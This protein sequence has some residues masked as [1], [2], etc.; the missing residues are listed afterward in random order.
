MDSTL[1]STIIARM[2]RWQE[3]LPTEEQYLVYDLDEALRTQI[4][5]YNFPWTLKKSTLKVFSEILE[6]PVA[7]D[8]NALA[9]IDGKEET[10]GEKPRPYYTSIIEFYQDPNN[11][12]SI[13]EIWDTGTRYL[14]VRNKELSGQNTTIDSAT[15]VTGY[16]VSGDATAVALDPVVTDGKSYSVAVS[17]TYSSNSFLVQRTFDAIQDTNYQKKYYFR[18][19]YIP[20]TATSVTLRYGTDSSNYLY[21]TVTTQFSGQPIKVGDFNWFAFDLNEGSVQGSGITNSTFAYEAVSITGI[22]SGT[23]YLSE[24]SV[25]QWS[26]MDYWYYSSYLIKTE[27]SSVPDREFFLDTSLVYS[28]DSSLIGDKEF[29]DVVMYEALMLAVA[30]KENNK[31]FGLFEKRS[32]DAWQAIKNRY[33]DLEPLITTQSYRF[34]SQMGN[35]V[36][37]YDSEGSW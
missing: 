24:S 6:Y 26:L 21:K 10:Y 1:L 18:R 22:A 7:D 4:R 9:Y 25:R 11:L 17:V 34:G 29:A 33:P 32:A 20:S 30:D 28:S 36:K 23:Y 19:M 12:S 5:S 31:L 16:T 3:V 8:H 27:N 14:G 35:V 2:Q 15:S 13:A 37:D